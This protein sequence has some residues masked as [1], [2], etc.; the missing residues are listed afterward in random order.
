[1]LRKTYLIAGCLVASVLSGTLSYAETDKAYTDTISSAASSNASTPNNF[2]LASQSLKK[3]EA[4]VVMKEGFSISEASSSLSQARVEVITKSEAL[5]SQEKNSYTLI[6][7][8]DST[9]DLVAK[10][11]QNPNVKSVSPNY[12]RTINTLPDDPRFG[13]LWGMNNTGQ[14]VNGT[15]GTAG[16]DVNAPEAWDINSDSSDAVIVVL[17]TGIFY[18]HEDLVDNMW[19]NESEIAGDGIDNDGNGFIDD[20]YGYDF[21]AELN[22]ANDSDPLDIDGHGTHVAGIIG[23]K[24][25]N[26]VGITGINWDVKIMALKVFRP[27]MKTYDSDIMEAINY[28]LMMKQ[29][30]INI[31][32]VNASYGSTSGSQTDPMNEAIKSLGRADIIFVAAAGNGGSNNVAHYPSSYDAHNIIS[33]AATDQEDNMA[34]FSNYGLKSID[35]AAPGANILSSIPGSAEVTASILNDDVESGNSNWLHSGTGDTWAITEEESN[36]PI[37]AWSDSPEGEYANNTDSSLTSSFDTDL[38]AF[39]GQNIGLGACLKYDIEDG[40]DYLYIEVSAD[41]GV[42]WNTLKAFTGTQSDWKCDAVIIP[43][44]VKTATFKMRFRLQTDRFKTADG[45]YIDNIGIGPIISSSAYSYDDSTSVATP[46]VS[47]SIA[48]IAKQ[49]PYESM[50]YRV[51]RILSGTDELTSLSGKVGSGGRLNIAGSIDPALVY[52][53]MILQAD[54]TQGLTKGSSVSLEGMEFGATQGK[55][56]F[57]SGHGSRVEGVV[58][59]WSDTK[60]TVTV[61]EGA[62]QFISLETSMQKASVTSIK[63]SA[64]K[65]VAPLGG[66]RTFASAVSY[67]DKIYVFGGRGPDD[68]N[69]SEIYEPATDTWTNIAPMPTP[70]YFVSATELNGKIYVIA[71]IDGTGTLTDIVEI[72]DPSTDSWA[73]TDAIAPLPKALFAGKGVTLEGS[74]YYVG[75][76]EFTPARIILNTLYKYNVADNSWSE[77]TSMSVPRITHEAVVHD[78]QIYVFGGHQGGSV[79][80]AITETYNPENETWTTVAEMP[81]T[82]WFLSA[83]PGPNGITIAGGDKSHHNDSDKV[84][85]YNPATDAWI[86]ENGSLKELI[87]PKV[88]S[89]LVFLPNRGYYIVGGGRRNILDGVDHLSANNAPVAE[90]D[91]ATVEENSTVDIA[92]LANDTDGDGGLPDISSVT[93]PKHGTAMIQGENISYKPNNNYIGSDSF[94]YTV[95][96][97]GGATDDAT[98]TVTVEAVSDDPLE[99]AKAAGALVKSLPRSDF[100]KH[101]KWRMKWLLNRSIFRIMWANW[102]GKSK[103][104]LKAQNI[105]KQA[106]SRTDGCVL[107]GKPDRNDYVNNCDAQPDVYKAIT[108]AINSLDTYI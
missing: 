36:S 95:N 24:G 83:A 37:Y 75:G 49:F 11:K 63:G 96:D 47:G 106:L 91:V 6:S 28:I 81:T 99:V 2:Y 105:L 10:F 102:T 89:S 40:W 51:N 54:R 77:K 65:Q 60:V 72:Y 87:T 97:I 71:G 44:T 1:M 16:A 98:V 108:Q 101:K 82:L 30:G 107:R 21:A 104:Y 68:L 90:N 50:L 92:V 33:V 73:Q 55:V 69:S 45:V 42:N 12:S 27:N 48:L 94:S 32:A 64:W 41:S 19:V 46:H 3:G 58:M 17:D 22:G 26:G 18:S 23:A 78:G 76:A 38:T 70:R 79:I 84:M 7:G 29:R 59:D 25:N 14:T 43:E 39:M 9:E 35:L 53:P 34:Q 4:I 100:K 80:H 86:E 57:S 52:R 20:I 85:H 67:N 74:L 66:P 103:H 88:A 93:M 15:A 56:H 5:S 31:V 13:D 61:P 8:D 62:G